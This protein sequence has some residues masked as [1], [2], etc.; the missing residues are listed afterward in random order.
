MISITEA[1][2]K[3]PSKFVDSLYEIFPTLTVDK[4]LIGMMNKRM[5]TIRTNNIKMT[6]RELMEVLKE[7]NIKFDRV[8]WYDDALIIKNA[9]EKDLQVLNEYKEGKFYIQSLS[10]MIPPIVLQPKEEEKILDMTAAP[11]SKTTQIAALM[12]NNGYILANELDKIRVEQL[13]YNIQCQGVN[14]VDVRQGRGEDLGKLYPEKFDKVLL[15]TPCSGEGR[16]IMNNVSTYRSWS[17][18]TVKELVKVQKKLL[19]SAYEAVKKGGIIVYSTCT[20]NNKENEEILDWALKNLDLEILD[21]NT[22]IKNT[23]PGFNDKYDQS[24]RKTIRVL[25]NKEMEGFF[26]AKMIKK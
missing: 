3:L 20:I 25:P 8:L 13:K 2:R 16:F 12:K 14:I 10:S 5:T 6:I 7:N 11:G 26:I 4:I 23:I 18:K 24:L 15:D 9:T 21:I 17:E 22:S 1:K 19:M